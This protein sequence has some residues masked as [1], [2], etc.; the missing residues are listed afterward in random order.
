M[1]TT[2][3]RRQFLPELKDFLDQLGKICLAGGQKLPLVLSGSSKNHPQALA[4]RRFDT[5]GAHCRE[6]AESS[7]VPGFRRPSSPVFLTV[8]RKNV[9]S[10]MD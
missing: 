6:G 1:S 8:L 5:G 7:P 4:S 9:I 3:E 2:S 10:L